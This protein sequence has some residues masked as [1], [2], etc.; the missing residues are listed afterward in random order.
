M[1][2]I[3]YFQGSNTTL[4][5]GDPSFDSSNIKTVVDDGMSPL[6]IGMD[7]N[8]TPFCACVAQMQ[9]N[10]LALDEVKVQTEMEGLRN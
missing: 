8:R 5:K 3:Y 1:V 10:T 4:K 6:I 9:G 7:Y 2:L